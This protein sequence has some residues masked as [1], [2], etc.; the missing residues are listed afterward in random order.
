MAK[1]MWVF[2]QCHVVGEGGGA[3]GGVHKRWVRL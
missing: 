2:L 1:D 3:K